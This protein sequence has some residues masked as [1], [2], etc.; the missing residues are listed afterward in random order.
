MT[1]KTGIHALDVQVAGAHYKDLPIQPVTYCQK[2]QLNYCE[3]NVIKYVT[4]HKAK[5]GVEDL[6]KARHYIDLLIQL[7]YGESP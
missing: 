3:S 2:N 6:R 5:A 4:R 7:E 1:D